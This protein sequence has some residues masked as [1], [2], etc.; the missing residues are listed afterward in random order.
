M[1]LSMRMGLRTGREAHTANR[2]HRLVL[3]RTAQIGGDY[4][5]VRDSQVQLHEAA[6]QRLMEGV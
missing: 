4:S 5:P 6:P 1:A 2:R 3:T